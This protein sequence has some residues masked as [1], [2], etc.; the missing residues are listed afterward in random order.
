VTRGGE[1]GTTMRIVFSNEASKVYLARW[2]PPKVFG[3]EVDKR[4]RLSDAEAVQWFDRIWNAS[5]EEGVRR[6]S[7]CDLNF[8]REKVPYKSQGFINDRA[9]HREFT[10]ANCLFIVQMTDATT[11]DQLWFIPSSS[12]DPRTVFVKFAT[13]EIKREFDA[14]ASKL[15]WKPEKL[16]EKL[17]LDFME[18]VNNR[19]YRNDRTEDAE[20]R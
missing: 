3:V 5:L 18:A 16:G 11:C 20:E 8:V 17:L 19:S 4:E 1:R 12:A 13:M 9:K 14:L 15:G 6:A 10:L 7:P 2:G